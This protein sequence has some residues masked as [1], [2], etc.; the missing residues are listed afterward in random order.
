MMTKTEKL[1][2]LVADVMKTLVRGAAAF[3]LVV[4]CAA[5]VLSV[6]ATIYQFCIV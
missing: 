1:K 4:M 5:T 6:A 2:M 3:F